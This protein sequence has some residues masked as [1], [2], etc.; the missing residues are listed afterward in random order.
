VRY[1]GAPDAFQS[2][3]RE[4]RR[5][6]QRRRYACTRRYLP[7]RAALP[8]QPCVEPP[9]EVARGL[10]CPRSLQRKHAAP[11][12]GVVPSATGAAQ[13]MT[14]ET[15]QLSWRGDQAITKIGIA[16]EEFGARHGESLLPSDED[17]VPGYVLSHPLAGGCGV[18]TPAG[19][20]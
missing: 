6:D 1:L 7:G 3:H 9:S 10:D 4:C 14:F 2:Q 5:E 16:F 13:E 12:G 18:P 20:R 8:L 17:R 15:A 11:H 19:A